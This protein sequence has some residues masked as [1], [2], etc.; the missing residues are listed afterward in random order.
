MNFL[1]LGDVSLRQVPGQGNRYPGQACHAPALV[2]REV[3]VT[4]ML[5]AVIGQLENPCALIHKSAVHQTGMRKGIKRTIH[6]Y[7][8]HAR[9][10][11]AF[12]D[13][14]VR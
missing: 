5:A 14:G 10:T 12:A 11:H 3:R 4:L 2:T 13:I 8:V 1:T 9:P 7:A 6:G